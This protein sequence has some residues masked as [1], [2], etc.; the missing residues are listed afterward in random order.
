VEQQGKGFGTADACRSTPKRKDEIAVRIHRVGP[1]HF[2]FFLSA[3]NGVHCRFDTVP[4][5]W[6]PSAKVNHRDKVGC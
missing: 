6:L 1:D 2:S 3:F 4:F 5:L